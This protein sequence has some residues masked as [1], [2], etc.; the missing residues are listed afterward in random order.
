MKLIDPVPCH[1]PVTATGITV[2][3][4]PVAIWFHCHPS[5]WWVFT[6]PAV[7]AAGNAAVISSLSA[8][9]SMIAAAWSSWCFINITS[10]SL[11]AWAAA[12]YCYIMKAAAGIHDTAGR[13]VSV[14]LHMPVDPWRFGP[15]VTIL[16]RAV[17]NLPHELL[18]P[19]IEAELKMLWDYKSLFVRLNREDRL[20]VVKIRLMSWLRR[21]LTLSFP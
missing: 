7:N 1:L 6:W 9:S 17:L 15:Q 12:C 8:V 21:T 4:W 5:A 20:H 2:K 18:D 13:P 10:A 14:L 16:Q 3:F 11:S 19:P